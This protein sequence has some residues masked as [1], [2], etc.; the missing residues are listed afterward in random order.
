VV[1]GH[2]RRWQDCSDDHELPLAQL[3]SVQVLL[4]YRG[5]DGDDGWSG[6]RPGKAGHVHLASSM[7]SHGGHD[8]VSGGG[9]A[10]AVRQWCVG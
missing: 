2:L 8:R 3:T 10:V 5:L 1:R 9:E 7:A 4:A 6:G